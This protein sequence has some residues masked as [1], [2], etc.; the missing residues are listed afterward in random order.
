MRNVLRDRA[1]P[2]SEL[3]IA[4][5]IPAHRAAERYVQVKGDRLIGI[6]AG[7]PVP[8]I[9]FRKVWLEV[10]RGWIARIAWDA[11]ASVFL[12][13]LG[14]NHGQPVLLWLARVGHVVKVRSMI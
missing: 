11:N 5:A 2:M 12:E 13:L 14:C 3:H 7:K 9:R 4:T 10:R 8:V 1:N 6:K